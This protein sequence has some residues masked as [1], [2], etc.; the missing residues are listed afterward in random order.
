MHVLL[1]TNIYLTDLTLE[2]SSFQALRE[3]LKLTSSKLIIPEIIKR[4]LIH[5][6]RHQAIN[7]VEKFHS[8]YISRNN[9]V[10][11][12][13][14]AEAVA[15]EYEKKIISN[16]KRFP[17]IE[18]PFPSE[19]LPKIIDRSIHNLPPFTKEGRGFKDALIWESLLTQLETLPKNENI[20]FI[21]ANHHDFGVNGLYKSLYED[22]KNIK[23]EKKLY[24]Y[25]NL[26]LFLTDYSEK[27]KFINEEFIIINTNDFLNENIKDSDGRDLDY[28]PPYDSEFQYCEC[29]NDKEV[30]TFY[31]FKADKK[32]Y[33]VYA[34][35]AIYF[36]AKFDV[37]ADDWIFTKDGDRI[38]IYRYETEYLNAPLYMSL[39]LTVE[40][41]SQKVINIEYG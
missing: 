15:E 2:K 10:K 4:E 9:I 18:I 30:T 16:L 29:T 32:N 19:S 31:I 8:S 38:P 34:E 37:K 40:K 27:V 1:D 20:A 22:L 23:C 6:A 33:Y 41:N 21:S 5:N 35:I 28:N 14:E 12:V 17:F 7:D 11:V 13:L 24:Y 26:D 3:Y 25:N 36:S 39:N